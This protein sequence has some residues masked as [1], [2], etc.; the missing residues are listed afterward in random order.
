MNHHFS[1]VWHHMTKIIC[2]IPKDT[3]HYERIRILQ[4][5]ANLGF[6]NVII[7]C[8][9]SNGQVQFTLMSSLNMMSIKIENSLDLHETFPDKLKN[10]NGY[11]YTVMVFNQPPRVLVNEKTILSPL[12]Y[13]L[14]LVLKVQKSRVFYAIIQNPQDLEYF[15]MNRKFHLTLNTA[16]RMENLEPKLLTYEK[17]GYCALI[18]LPKA[19]TLFQLFFI[20]PFDGLTWLFLVLSVSCSAFVF[21]MFRHQGAV[22]SPQLL[23]Y[24]IFV[25]FIGQGFKFSRKNRLV[26]AVL[27]Q[28]IIFMVFILSNGYQG[29]ITSFMIQP[30]HETRM[31]TI[32]ELLESDYEILTD[33]AFAFTVRD[34]ED[35]EAIKSR[36][37]TSGASIRDDKLDDL[38][39]NKRYV[40]I[41]VC[42]IAEMYLTSQLENHKKISDYFYLMPEIIQPYYV[43]LEASFLN[44]FLERFQYFM[45]LS[46]QAGLMHIWKVM[47]QQKY[48]EP[49]KH[50]MDDEVG[51]LKFKDLKQVFVL[52]GIGY[53]LSAVVLLLEISFYDCLKHLHLAHL[54]RKL[55]NRVHQIA[56][57]KNPKNPKYRKGALYYIINRHRKVK[58]LQPKKLKVRKIFEQPINPVEEV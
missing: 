34:N 25:M 12:T 48:Y 16:V 56:Y 18:P 31:T 6:L 28:L 3:V 7:A 5:F 33:T 40:L 52:L 49:K 9:S 20:E 41:R 14:Q 45:D 38:I 24:G 27:L 57:K 47:S 53:I 10:M 30:F 44:P 21:W 32:K 54:A 1:A 39:I 58:R 17:D 50:K 46:F 35:F 51:Y 22:D 15:W 36:M 19:V 23:I 8:D 13:F 55:R 4:T 11:Q 26:Q 43:Q 42:D 29:V 37:N 2:I